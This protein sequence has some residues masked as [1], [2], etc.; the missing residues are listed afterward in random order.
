[1]VKEY[2]R[3]HKE[4]IA[5]SKKLHH[6][7]NRDLDLSKMKTYYE[8]HR[9]HILSKRRAYA[10]KNSE[11]IASYQKSYRD[12]HKDEKYAYT[13]KYRKEHKLELN[14]K[15]RLRRAIK[16][17]KPKCVIDSIMCEIDAIKKG[18]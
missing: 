16:A 18:R 1:M 10:D 12:T 11:K 13:V 6:E 7:R 9:D 3:L 4:E 15:L 8:E 17:N 14:A 2:I 5:L